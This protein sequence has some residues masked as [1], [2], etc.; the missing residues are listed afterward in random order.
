MKN[1]MAKKLASGLLSAVLALSGLIASSAEKMDY[2][3]VIQPQYEDVRQFNG[4]FA[5]VKNGGKW[6]YIDKDGNPVTEFI[7]DYAADFYEGKAV[8]GTLS[9]EYG[10]YALGFVD[11]TGQYTPFML[12]GAPYICYELFYIGED[13][14]PVMNELAYSNGYLSVEEGGGTW[15]IFDKNG[16]AIDNMFF[17]G[18]NNIYLAG[19]YRE[20]LFTA[21]PEAAYPENADYYDINKN[22]VLRFPG[23]YDSAGIDGFRVLSSFEFYNGYAGG[24]ALP[25]GSNGEDG[26]YYFVLLDRSGHIA[27][28]RKAGLVSI[29]SELGTLGHSVLN[30]G[31]I[32]LTDPATGKFGAVDINNNVHIPFEYEEL[33]SLCEGLSLMKKNGLF[34]YVDASGKVM[35]EPQYEMATGFSNGIAFAVKN[36]KSLAIDR[37][38]NV[39][40]GSENIPMGHYVRNG[41]VHN[42]T[43]MMIIEENGKFGFAALSYDTALPLE[44]EMSPWAYPEVIEAIKTDLIP[45]Y[46]QNNYFANITRKDFAELIVTALAEVTGKSSYD[47]LAEKTGIAKKDLYSV[48]PFTDTSDESVIIANRLGIIN[49]VSETSFAPESEI[50]RQDA[51][52]LLMRAAE[53]ISGG[54][55]VSASAFSDDDRIADYAKR[56]VSY[57]TTLKIMN[58]V[59]NDRFD[60]TAYYSREQAYITILRLFKSLKG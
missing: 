43:K 9:G 21:S 56:A 57:V 46:L 40:E 59:G 2:K 29:R 3:V 49:G 52:A 54:K 32:I 1:T 58:G 37:Y 22:L 30:S 33:Y 5:A 44:S 16:A 7:Y 12:N 24:W 17:D 8:V 11:I 35:I 4:G 48:N 19:L 23:G 31:L 6:G 14:N 20:G 26:V 38:N 51:A 28:S 55:E 27:F 18:T 42:A 45:L 10:G 34:G 25:V 47:L 60:P 13:G 41:F 53:L 36:G 39:L 50:K 15:Y